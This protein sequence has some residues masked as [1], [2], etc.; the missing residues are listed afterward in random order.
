MKKTLTTIIIIIILG[1]GG[2]AWWY[3]KARGNTAE[4]NPENTGQSTQNNPAADNKTDT[5]WKIATATLPARP[6]Q[7]SQPSN[8]N[9]FA[10][11][12]FS[13]SYPDGWQSIP[14]QIGIL[15]MLIKQN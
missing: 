12:D 7:N 2:A 5:P 14:P 6:A 3:I 11:E 4:K 13:F 8:Q 1:I 9:V 10:N 15:A